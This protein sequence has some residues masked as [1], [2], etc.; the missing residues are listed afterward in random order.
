MGSTH[1]ASE[2]GIEV[3]GKDPD[4]VKDKLEIVN[5]K[6]FKLSRAES[7]WSGFSQVDGEI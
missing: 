4:G 5:L 2:G 3:R 6:D 1:G 7:S